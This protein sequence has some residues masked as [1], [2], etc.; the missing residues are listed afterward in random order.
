MVT[1]MFDNDFVFAYR[2]LTDECHDIKLALQEYS[3]WQNLSSHEALS[4]A[5]VMRHR[6]QSAS[7][8]KN[9][10]C[11]VPK[12]P[13]ITLEMPSLNVLSSLQHLGRLKVESRGSQTASSEDILTPLHGSLIDGTELP[14]KKRRETLS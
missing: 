2:S 7:V 3:T 4:K 1:N 6:L 10:V 9:S 14:A 8:P 5:N 11:N 13:K 12:L